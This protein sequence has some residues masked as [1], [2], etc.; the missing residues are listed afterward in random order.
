MIGIILYIVRRQFTILGIYRAGIDLQR[1]IVVIFEIEIGLRAFTLHDELGAVHIFHNA[2][3]STTI[4][5]FAAFH[6]EFCIV[7]VDDIFTEGSALHRERLFIQNRSINHTI[8]HGDRIFVLQDISGGVMHIN[9]DI[10]IK[11]NIQRSFVDNPAP[12]V[13]GT[14]IL[15]RQLRIFFNLEHPETHAIMQAKFHRLSAGHRERGSIQADILKAVL[16]ACIQF[17]LNRCRRAAHRNQGMLRTC[18]PRQCAGSSH[19]HREKC[20][21]RNYFLHLFILPSPVGQKIPA[22]II[23]HFPFSNKRYSKEFIY[24]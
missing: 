18:L 5:D 8:F 12:K 23:I 13:N 22:H 11:I 21:H 4:P 7:R 9:I 3:G 20:Q 6:H 16:S 19:H 14:H 10:F 17:C 24:M 15:Q 2:I 1:T